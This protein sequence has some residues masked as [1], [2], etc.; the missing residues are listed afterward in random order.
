VTTLDQAAESVAAQW[1]AEWG[2]TTTFCLPNENF[3]KPASGPF[4]RLLVQH[5]PGGNATLGATGFRRHTRQARVFIHV[6][7]DAD[8]G[9]RRLNQLAQQARA[10]FESRSFSGLRFFPADVR[11]GADEGRHK[12]M[13]V[14]APF[15]YQ[16]TK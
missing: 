10:V 9:T 11:E 1:V 14:D 2:A 5:R 15:D 6:Y 4:V 8:I 12:Q 13:I 7:D 3:A 16:E